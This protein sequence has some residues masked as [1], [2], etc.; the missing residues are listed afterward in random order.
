MRASSLKEKTCIPCH[1]GTKPLGPSEIE[2]LQEHVDRW[3]VVDNHHLR[4]VFRFIDFAQAMEFARRV[5]Y[6][7]DEQGH[8]PEI[9]IAWGRVDVRVWTHLINGLTMSD[10]VLAAK[11]DAL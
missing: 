1:A 3:A 4:R 5:G 9:T 10:F 8:H 2:Q 7:S 6:L 11:I